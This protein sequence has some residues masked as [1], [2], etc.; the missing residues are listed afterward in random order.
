MTGT[1][2]AGVILAAG[3]S[4]RMGEPK[5]LLRI[6]PSGPTF[7]LQVVGT[8]RRAGLDTIVVVVGV[9]GEQIRAAVATV[10]P[11]VE[12]AVNE[13]PSRGQLSSLITAL[14][15]ADRPEVEAV[16]VTPVDQPLISVETVTEV[17]AAYQRTRAP[18]VRPAHGARH[19][20]PVIFDRSVFDELRRADLSAGARSV[21]RAHEAAAIDVPVD[22]EG[23]FTDID[24]RDDY[25]RLCG[26]LRRED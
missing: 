6:G 12:V 10:T 18:I 22:D 19:G 20:H 16:L 17:I 7:L 24:T 11:P 23:A 4:V 1:M 13:D 15:L 26:S 21:I 2:I 25:E 8:L 3:Y 14:D 5:A 9:H